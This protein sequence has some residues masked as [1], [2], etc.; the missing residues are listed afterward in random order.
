MPSP[1]FQAQPPPSAANPA[2]GRID[3]AVA[4]AVNQADAS[5]HFSPELISQV[6]ATVIQQLQ[7]YGLGSPQ[8]QQQ[9][10]QP[11]PPPPPQAPPVL[12]TTYYE[13]PPASR[14]RSTESPEAREAKSTYSIPIETRDGS[15]RPSPGK[16][17]DAGSESRPTMSE[18]IPKSSDEMTTL[19]KI[20]G[21]MFEDGKPTPRLGQLL[22]GIAVH[23]VILF[24]PGSEI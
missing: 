17:S 23:L 21:R 10:Q 2:G 8:Q 14:Y 7:A 20:W 5:N 19:E 16:V 4:S 6:T 13:P 22:R 12:D 9:Q 1:S 18:R 24:Q 15:R 11:P 3:D